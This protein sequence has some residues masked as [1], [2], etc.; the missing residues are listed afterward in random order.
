VTLF[1]CFVCVICVIGQWMVFDLH[2]SAISFS[3]VSDEDYHTVDGDGGS[4]SSRNVDKKSNT[5]NIVTIINQNVASDTTVSIEGIQPALL[6][7]EGR[8]KQHLFVHIGKAGG[9]SIQ[10]MVKKSRESCKELTA[11]EETNKRNSSSNSDSD[12]KKLLKAQVCALATIPEGRVHLKARLH[13]QKFYAKYTQFLINLRD[14][15][16]RLVS[17]YNYEL[18]SYRKEPLWSSA[19]QTGQASDNFRRLTKECYPGDK[20]EDGFAKMVREG[21]LSSPF[22][23]QEQSDGGAIQPCDKLARFCL[24]GDIMCFG[25]NYYNYEVYLEEILLRKGLSVPNPDNHRQERIRIDA[26]RSEYSMQDFNRTVGLWTSNTIEEWKEFPGVAP[27]VQSLYGRVRS[28]ESYKGAIKT[29][30]PKPEVLGPEARTALCK[31]ICAELV[32][33]KLALRAADNLDA[34]DVRESFEAL[35]DHCGIRVDEVCGTTWTFRDIKS[36]KKVF[37]EAPW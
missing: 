26:I 10:I 36:Q 8:S 19:N 21:L 37:E 16:D 11:M 17:W 34:S 20:T 13:P 24:R 28:I 30:Q 9:S 5:A 1:L 35:D 23:K 2:K 12:D 6:S 27:F 31:H 4:S 22:D 29:E 3:V 25:H 33:Y 18:A 7:P 15:I 32:V 14:P